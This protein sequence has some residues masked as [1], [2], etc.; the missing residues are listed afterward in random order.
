MS[1]YQRQVNR[2][3]IQIVKLLGQWELFDHFTIIVFEWFS[4]KDLFHFSSGFIGCL[5]LKDRRGV[6]HPA[7]EPFPVSLD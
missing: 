6:H 4:S 7:R 5:P 2:R 1:C 3:G